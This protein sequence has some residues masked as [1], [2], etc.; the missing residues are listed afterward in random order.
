MS[1]A[2]GANAPQSGGVHPVRECVDLDHVLARVREVAVWVADGGRR[3]D[4]A[5][6][7]LRTDAEGWHSLVFNDP[8]IAELILRMRALPGFDRDRLV[9]AVCSQTARITAVWSAPY[10][11]GGRPPGGIEDPRIA[12]DTVDI[13]G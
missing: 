4:D 8:R 10:A 1:E 12:G 2:S 11:A 3:P 5:V 7:L 6:F 9:D 13:T